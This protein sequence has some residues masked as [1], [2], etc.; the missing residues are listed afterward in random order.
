ME[1]K[2]LEA[3]RSARDFED[4]V[5]Q[6]DD[7]IKQLEYELRKARDDTA[8]LENRIKE[9]GLQ[10]ERDNLRWLE[11]ERDLRAGLQEAHDHIFRLQPRR[12]SI[13]ETEAQEDF[14]GLVASVQRWVENRL[15]AILDE[16]DD[17]S[18]RHK[19]CDPQLATKFLQL[20]SSQAKKYT[21]ASESDEFHVVA[22]IMQYLCYE[23]FDKKFYCPLPDHRDE[24]ATIIQLMD[25]VEHGLMRLGRETAICRGWRSDTLTA[26]A[27]EPE[28]TS[29]RLNYARYRTEDLAKMLS[30]LVPDTGFQEL[31]DSIWRSIITPAIDLAHNLHLAT[32]I[33]TVEWSSLGMV[34]NKNGNEARYDFNRYT[35]L[36][37]LEAG[38]IL[39]FTSQHSSKDDLRIVYLFD[40]CPGLVFRKDTDEHSTTR[41]TL[42]KP[43]VLVAAS[44]EKPPVWRRG[45]T[46]LEW[47]REQAEAEQ[48]TSDRS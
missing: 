16:L 17:G 47:L 41:R 11:T 33:Y 43:K 35:C 27:S 4:A 20:T 25:R 39:K 6:K 2:L 24:A 32:D 12:R 40:V 9:Q 26:L 14:Q 3:E 22:A 28:F 44:K 36:N 23:F 19:R 45:S 48:G 42:C 7:T 10:L 21:N 31:Y 1:A 15:S 18:L 29:R 46:L 30:I 34:A 8:A 37:V 5:I 13:T 38:K